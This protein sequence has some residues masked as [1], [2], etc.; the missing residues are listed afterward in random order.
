MRAPAFLR[1]FAKDIIDFF[2]IMVVSCLITALV[3]QVS[4]QYHA[5]EMSF[6][7]FEQFI[8]L[9]FLNPELLVWFFGTAC[10]FTL[11][12]FLVG[13]LVG[14]TTL[15]GALLGLKIL[16]RKNQQPLGLGQIFLRALGAIIG[17]SAFMIGP[18][19]AWF[20]DSAHRGA[21][22]FFSRSLL[23]DAKDLKNS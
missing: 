3:Y 11:V 23:F 6:Y 18:L 8:E 15:G 10:G 17:V 16:D 20:L 19:Y 2:T 5:I 22:E 9:F 13:A 21:A 1:V 7:F 14:N 12:Y 4:P